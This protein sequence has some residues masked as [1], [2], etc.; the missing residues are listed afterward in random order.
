MAFYRIFTQNPPVHLL[1]LELL[2]IPSSNFNVIRLQLHGPQR[3]EE[4]GLADREAYR[5]VGS[6]LKN[7]LENYK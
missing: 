5:L 6:I 1:A 7:F 3:Y 2:G 4:I